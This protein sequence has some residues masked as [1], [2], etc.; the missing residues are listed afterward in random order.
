MMGPDLGWFQIFGPTNRFGWS[1]PFGEAKLLLQTPEGL[2]PGRH[3]AKVKVSIRTLAQTNGSVMWA[4]AVAADP[5]VRW[6]EREVAFDVSPPDQ[7]TV[8]TIAPSE[9]ERQKMESI[10][11][12]TN[13][14]AYVYAPLQ[15][16][17]V[18]VQFNTEGAPLGGAFEVYLKSREAAWRIGSFTTGT[19]AANEANAFS[20]PGMNKQRFVSGAVPGFKAGTYDLE[21]RPSVTEAEKTL[22]VERIYGAAIVF[23][24]LDIAVDDQSSRMTRRVAVKR[25]TSGGDSTVGSSADDSSGLK[26]PQ[27]GFFESVDRI[28]HGRSP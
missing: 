9:G 22:D 1:A 15:P 18:Q 17:V 16:P 28:L 13:I 2:A 12:T 24:G 21:L 10:L 4:A 6:D 7:P 3:T 27:H 20:M 25:T 11:D 8:Q 23:P 26:S 19:S 5:E 14:S